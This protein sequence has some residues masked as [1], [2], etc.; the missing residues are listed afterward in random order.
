[1]KRKENKCS[2]NAQ[3]IKKCEF[4][5]CTS[6]LKDNARGLSCGDCSAP[7]LKKDKGRC[8]YFCPEKDNAR[9][10]D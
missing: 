9:G 3:L 10:L 8:L 2:A 7:S 4:S 5:K 6:P 1:M